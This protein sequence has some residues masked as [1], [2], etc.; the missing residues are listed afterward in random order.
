[1]FYYA[2]RWE[3]EFLD[4]NEINDIFKKKTLLGTYSRVQ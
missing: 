4:I 1:M 2:K 3:F